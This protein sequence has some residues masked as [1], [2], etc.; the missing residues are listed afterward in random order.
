MLTKADYPCICLALLLA[1]VSS[2]CKAADTWST[3]QKALGWTWGALQA[4]D[5]MQTRYIAKHP[6]RYREVGSERWIGEHPTTKEVTKY[7]IGSTVFKLTL[8]HLMPTDFPIFNRTNFQ[9]LNIVYTGSTVY[10][11]NKIGIGIDVPFK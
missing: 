9:Y 1:A 7:F 5:Y 3:E 4:I 11:N 6:D 2:Q 10:H 8:M